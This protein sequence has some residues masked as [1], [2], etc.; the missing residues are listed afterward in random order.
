MLTGSFMRQ[1]NNLSVALLLPGK[2]DT[3]LA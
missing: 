3:S 1:F 2:P